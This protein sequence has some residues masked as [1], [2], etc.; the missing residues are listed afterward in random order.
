MAL[1]EEIIE[2]SK[3]INVDTYSMS[4]GELISM[5]R[6]GELNIHPEFQRFYRWTNI[7]KTR[8]IE[9]FLLNIPVPSIF[10]SQNEDGIWEIV[11]G[12]QRVSTILQ[13]AGCYKDENG[14]TLS[15]L[16]LSGT[17]FLPSLEGKIYSETLKGALPEEHPAFGLEEQRFFKRAKVNLVILKKESDISGKYELFQR[18]NTGGT[19][20]SDQEVRNCIMLMENRELFMKLQELSG[21]EPYKSTLRINDKLFKER[22]D[23][24]LL[25]RFICLRKE[26][27]NS[28]NPK[29]FSEYLNKRIVAL[30]NSP[31]WDIDEEI[32]IFKT[33]FAN[34]YNAL[35]EE[36][37]CKYF[38]AEDKFKG[39]TITPAFEMIAIGLGR[40]GGTLPQDFELKDKVKEFWR[41]NGANIP[42]KGQSAKDR[43]PNMMNLSSEFYGQN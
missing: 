43:I 15:P 42:W 7:Q 32:N 2:R 5:Y 18:L 34:I 23:M 19:S 41:K 11:D 20:L 36:V 29:D 28:F 31:D 10:V 14:Q 24:E 27:M 1:L 39:S 30:F 33:T 35:G 9:S 8:L 38:P 6:D 22:F 25:T 13:F 21:Y 12:L 4:V 16:V 37:F 40:I 3:N 17:D 26:D